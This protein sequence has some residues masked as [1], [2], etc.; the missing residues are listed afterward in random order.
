MEIVRISE[1]EGVD[2]VSKRKDSKVLLGSVAEGVA[3]LSKI[4]VLI[5]SE[6]NVFDRILHFHHFL[7]SKVPEILINLCG[8][9]RR[10]YILRSF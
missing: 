9:A 5:I 8:I 6:T 4:P 1:N 3:I 7:E 2:L 10:V